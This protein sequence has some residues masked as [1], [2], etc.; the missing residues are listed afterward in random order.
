[1]KTIVI[2]LVPAYNE[3]ICIKDTLSSLFAIDIIDRIYVV[4][5]ASSDST[6][7]NAEASG[8]EVIRLRRNLG[9][10]KALN[11]A[12]T[13]IDDYDVLLLID[14]DLGE[15]AKEAYKLIDPVVNKEADMAIANFP[16]PHVKGGFGLVKGLAAWGIRKS[17]GLSVKEPLSG[18]RAISREVIQ[19]VGKFDSGFGVEVG[20][21]I[22]AARKGFKI[23]EVDTTMSH[24][25][26]GRNL[27]GFVHRGKQFYHVLK[28]IIRRLR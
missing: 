6:A 13:S 11:N 26:T 9:K 24:A 19:A 21:T 10:G 3:E 12:L 20:L 17:G 5:D 14:C 4:D 27:A 7:D 15:S 18:Q 1:M 25:E 2:A 8:A 22:D 16:K 28:A 23:I